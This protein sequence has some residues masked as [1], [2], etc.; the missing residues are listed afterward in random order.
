M[1][2]IIEVSQTELV[3]LLFRVIKARQFYQIEARKLDGSPYRLQS[4]PPRRAAVAALKGTG[5]PA[6]PDCVTIYAYD[7]NGW[8]TPKIRSI[9]ALHWQGKVYHCGTVR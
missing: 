3:A 1:K 9:S 5:R 7:R 6:N 4:G 2:P 8:R